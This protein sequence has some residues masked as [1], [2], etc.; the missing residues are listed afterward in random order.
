VVRTCVL[1]LV[2]GGV[3]VLYEL[4]LVHGLAGRERRCVSSFSGGCSMDAGTISAKRQSMLCVHG[5]FCRAGQF[6]AC[7]LLT[8][9]RQ[10]RVLVR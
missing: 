2:Y 8:C 6:M 9:L 3:C 10:A 1:G 5:Q 4:G 7:R